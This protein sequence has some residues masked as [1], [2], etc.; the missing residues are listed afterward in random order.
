MR[1]P[2]AAVVPLFLPLIA[3][4]PVL[5]NDS[6]AELSVGGLVLARSNDV[7]LQSEHLTISPDA[8]SVRYQFVNE[9]ERP[10]TLT[11]AF[12]LP[13]IDLSL[14]D[15]YSIPYSDGVNLLEFQTKVA[16]KLVNFTTHQRA[17]LGDKDVSDSLR[18][19]GLAVLPVGA[20][21]N[22]ISDLPE[23]KRS[24]LVQQGL[25]LENGSDDLGRPR[26]E[27]AWTIKTAALRTQT[28]EP[29]RPVVVEHSYRPGLGRSLDTVLRKALRQDTATAPQVNRYRKDYCIGDEF[30]AKVDKLAE[31][32]ASKLQEQRISYVLKTGA[33]WAGPIKN[34]KLTV[35]KRNPNRLVSF[36]ADHIKVISPTVVEFTASDFTPD[37]DLKILILG[38]F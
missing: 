1:A 2:L 16:G 30:L 6:S 10:V 22:P 17:F 34:F 27:P 24:Q 19:V 8:I 15:I 18:S 7:A 21:H 38:R 11:V 37:K 25:L 9:T 32:A 3:S 13:D 12:V 28:F 29:K 26:Y 36:C 23:T 20:E 4:F 35:D 33:N 14:E 5:A 31:S